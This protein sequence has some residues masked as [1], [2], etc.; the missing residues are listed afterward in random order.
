MPGTPNTLPRT[1]VIDPFQSKPLG[2]FR[3]IIC[4][5]QWGYHNQTILAIL[6]AIPMFG[7]G[8]CAGHYVILLASHADFRFFHP[9]LAQNLPE[10]FIAGIVMAA[11]GLVFLLRYSEEEPAWVVALPC[12]GI[13]GTFVGLLATYLI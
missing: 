4:M 7:V 5:T 11:M 13:V 3:R 6:V 10:Y 12:S 1:Y 9:V 8:F 2:K